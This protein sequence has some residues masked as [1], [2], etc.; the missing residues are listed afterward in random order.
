MGKS[1]GVA[2][3]KI[4]A[5]D[6]IT[7]SA[8]LPLMHVDRESYLR[9]QFDKYCSDEKLDKVVELGPAGAGISR[10]IINQVAKST[11]THETAMVT[12][13][14]TAAGIPGG[15]AMAAT[16]PADIAQ[17]HAALIR[18]SQKLAYVHG[19]PRLFEDKGK[20]ID[21]ETRSVL[22]IFIGVMYG[23]SGAVGALEKLSLH[24]SEVAM[25]KIMTTALTKGTV[26]PLIKKISKALGIRMT[27]RLLANSAGK[28]VPIV[29]GILSGAIT[30]A[31]FRPMANRLNAHLLRRQ[32]TKSRAI[33]N[34]S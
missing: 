11:I 1:T 29:G 6:L 7:W 25:N 23:V 16:I 12:L 2:I 21:D 8:S 31:S 18:T 26:Y 28:A 32:T 17:F 5:D 27:K 10:K 14:S 15:W 20:N 13:I 33:R 22:L 4:D 24:F 19:W 34:E 30:L 9:A 3:R